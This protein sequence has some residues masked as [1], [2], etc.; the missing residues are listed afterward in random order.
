MFPAPRASFASSLFEQRVTEML[1]SVSGFMTCGRTSSATSGSRSSRSAFVA[2]T[3]LR[4]AKELASAFEFAVHPP[5]DHGPEALA[6]ERLDQGELLELEVWLGAIQ[7]HGQFEPLH[8]VGGRK[9][10]FVLVRG[11]Q[12]FLAD[13]QERD[14]LPVALDRPVLDVNYHLTEIDLH[15]PSASRIFRSRS[16]SASRFCSTSLSRSPS[17]K[18]PS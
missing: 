18:S 5:D 10:L 17:S 13:V 1:F 6:D 2:L 7:L 15:C 4:R 8:L 14:R 11:D 9:V 12:G 3:S 16:S